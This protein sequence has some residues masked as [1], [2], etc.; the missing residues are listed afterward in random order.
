[1]SAHLT[2]KD[3]KKKTFVGSP[4]WMAPEVIETQLDKSVYGPSADIWSLGITAIE[5]AEMLPP[6][7]H[8]HPMRAMYLIPTQKPPKLKDQKKW[9]KAFHDF[10]KDCLT[11]N[12]SKRPTATELLK[13]PFIAQHASLDIKDTFRPFIQETMDLRKKRKRS[14]LRKIGIAE[15]MIDT[16]FET[17]P[18][19]NLL[20][21]ED[22]GPQISK[23]EDAS[24]IL[25]SIKNGKTPVRTLGRLVEWYDFLGE[26]PEDYGLEVKV[27][28][29]EPVPSPPA[30]PIRHERSSSSRSLITNQ[31][32]EVFTPSHT[33]ETVFFY[34][35][36]SFLPSTYLLLFF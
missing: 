30:S 7:G 12:Q 19:P 1:M 29:E 32:T 28:S 24:E 23:P 3:H 35:S 10:L 11:K 36:L 2:G 22:S 31:S 4:Y 26:N 6:H 14:L 20:V 27:S 21:S 17:G 25:E 13:H 34:V 5:M 18:A 33:E 15:E 16:Y 8:L 9:S